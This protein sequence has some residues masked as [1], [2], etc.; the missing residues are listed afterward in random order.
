M[1]TRVD[2]LVNQLCCEIDDLNERLEAAKVEAGHYRDKYN[3]LLASNIKHN[4]TMMANILEIAVGARE[5]S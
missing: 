5:N 1:K 3:E 4:E 2:A